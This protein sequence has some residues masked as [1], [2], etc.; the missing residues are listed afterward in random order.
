M[1]CAIA[2]SMLMAV[3]ELNRYTVQAGI[4]DTYTDSNTR[5]RRPYEADGLVEATAHLWLQRDVMW[6]RHSH[7]YVIQY[8][9][10]P[11]EWVQVR[12]RLPISLLPL[13][14]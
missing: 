3:W 1:Q 5:E 13:Q 14:R 2:R 8:P 11:V 10:W 4:L 7:A 12:Y 9:T 6:A